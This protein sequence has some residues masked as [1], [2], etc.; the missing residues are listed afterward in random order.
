MIQNKQIRYSGLYN[1]KC[2]YGGIVNAT[3]YYNE[4]PLASNNSCKTAQYP[5]VEFTEAHNNYKVG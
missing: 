1:R 4:R 2:N 5:V 3:Q